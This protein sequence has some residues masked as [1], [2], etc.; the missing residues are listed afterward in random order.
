VD[1]VADPLHLRKSRSARNRTRT[2]GSVAGNSDH[3]TTEAVKA[4]KHAINVSFTLEILVAVISIFNKIVYYYHKM[5]EANNDGFLRTRVSGVKRTLSSAKPFYE[6]L[7]IALNSEDEETQR[8]FKICQ[9]QF[10]STERI[11]T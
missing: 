3:W 11:G 4:L 1:P 6:S 7:S 10:L 2:S 9:L 5:A 8:Y